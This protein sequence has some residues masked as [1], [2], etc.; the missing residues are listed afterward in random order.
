MRKLVEVQ[1]A[2][3]LMSEA[4]DWSVF[5]W[6]LEKS[7]VRETADQANAA[8]DASERAVKARWSNEAKAAYKMMAKAAKAAG[9]GQADPK[10]EQTIDSAFLVLIEEVVHADDAAKHARMDAEDTFDEAEKQLSVSMAR[11]GCRKAIHSW[12]L[13]EKAIR[14]AE[15]VMDALRAQT[16]LSPVSREGQ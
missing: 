11:E 7:R 15:A 1:E 4:M 6:L 9:K 2:K 3:A 16:A 12:S 14:K 5:T 13:H 10:P 8:L